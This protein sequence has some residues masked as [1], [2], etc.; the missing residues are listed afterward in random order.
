MESEA[1]KNKLLLDRIA[2]LERH[3]GLKQLEIDYLNK[4]VEISSKE[5]KIDSKGS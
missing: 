1:H 2:E 4:L 3:V 5:L